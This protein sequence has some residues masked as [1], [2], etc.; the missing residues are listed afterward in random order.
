MVRLIAPPGTDECNIG[1]TRYRVHDDGSVLVPESAVPV[2]TTIAG[3]AMAPAQPVT[4]Q[5]VQPAPPADQAAEVAA[6][7]SEDP[8]L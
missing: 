3:F 2:L 7:F 5:P 1:T 8:E 4:V 6:A